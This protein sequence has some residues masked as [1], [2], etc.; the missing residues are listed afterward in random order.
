MSPLQDINHER[1]SDLHPMCEQFPSFPNC[2]APRI[3]S[4][5]ISNT[6]KH[7][8]LSHTFHASK[9]PRIQDSK[10]KTVAQLPKLKLAQLLKLKLAQLLKLKLAK[11]LLVSEIP[12]IRRIYRLY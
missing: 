6:P 1:G 5:I 7:F 12:N 10:S 11:L 3:K 2:Q 9:A 4:A 8:Q